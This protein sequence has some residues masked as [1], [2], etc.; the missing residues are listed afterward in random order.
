M[1]ARHLFQQYATDAYAKVEGERLR[2]VRSHQKE[3]R[4]DKYKGL[5]DAV[6]ENDTINAGQ[7]VILPPTYTGGPRWLAEEFQDSMALVRK[8]GKPDYFVTF[9]AK[10]SWP[11]ITSSLFP[12][13][14]PQDRQDICDRV[15]QIKHKSLLEDL[16]KWEVLGKVKAFTSTIEFQKRGL[17]H[18]HILLIMA[19][20]DKPR[21]PEE[22][23]RVVS[24]EIPDVTINPELHEIVTTQMVHGPC[25][26]VNP[27]SPCMESSAG[28][29]I[30]GKDFPKQFKESTSINPNGYPLYRRRAP[31]DGG[32]TH[33]TTVKGQQFTIDNRWIV[34]YNPFLSLKYK[35]HLNVEIVTSVECVKYIY[36]YICKGSDRVVI[37]LANGD[38]KDITNDEIECFV[39]ARYISSSQAL[40]R[41]Y[42]FNLSQ[43]H[44]PVSKLPL[45]LEDEQ[46]VYF[47]PGNASEV[48]SRP[49]PVTKLTGYFELN[50]QTSESHHILYPDIYKHYVWKDNKWVK[51]SRDWSK[52]K[53][54][55]AM[56]DIVGRIPVI[57]LNAQQIEL[58]H[59][60][61]LLYHI[62]GAKSFADLRTIN[63]VEEPTFRAA[64]L[65]M[66]LLDDD[67]ENDRAIEEAS[68]IRF[69]PQ[70]RETFAMLLIWNSPID[71]KAFWEKHKNILSEDLLRR[72]GLTEP[73][74]QILNEVLLNIEEYVQRNGFEIE[75]FQLPKP[76]HNL[77]SN[78]IPREIREESEYD[79]EMMTEIVQ[80]NVPLLNED[81]QKVYDTIIES[82]NTGK[83]EII[84]LDAA[85]GSGKTFLTTTIL[86]TLRSQGKVALAT[87]T[88]G[89]AATL[90]LNGR[91]LHSRCKVPVEGLNEH[92]FCNISKRGATAELIRRA[93]FLVVDEVTM[94]RREVYEA[95][96]RTFQDI[97]GNNLPFG[98]ITVLLS[99]DWRQIL[100]VVRHGGRADIVHACLKRSHLWKKVKVIKLTKNMRLNKD[101]A[102]FESFAQQ[103]LQIGEGKVPVEED[104]GEFKIKVDDDFL[105]NEETL[106]ALC[107]FVWNGLEDHYNEPEWLCSRAVLCPTNEA[108]DEV[109]TYM[110]E[111]FPGEE[112]CYF[113]SDQLIEGNKQ[114][115]PEEFLNTLSSSG[116]PPHKLLL[117][118]KCPV[119]LMRNLD[120]SKGHCNGTRYVISGMYDHVIDATIATGV[121][122][123]RRIMIP[124]IPTCPSES[125]FPFRMHRRQYPLRTCFGMTANKS[126][127]QGLKRIGIY[128]KKRFFS[129]GQLYVAMSR[130][131]S[132]SNIKIL[133]KDGRFPGKEG[134]YMDNVVYPEIL[135]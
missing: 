18:S 88:S 16:L 76:D 118:E 5:L 2:W 45:H 54:G 91:T 119:M 48:A 101:D 36:K 29:K 135:T 1:K 47:Q 27:L 23:D 7:K 11:E 24:A 55:S 134:V 96:D 62:P 41:L 90:L 68:S 28:G 70:L 12:G 113:S 92:S 130:V 72:D 39:N 93:V 67:S 61:M 44:P 4:A 30:C 40:W 108:A 34:P 58:Y 20:S 56:S 33:N 103:L 129:H 83:G 31:E 87:A 89:I 84:A 3:I 133:A 95:V 126:Q 73:N 74:D 69:G 110:T 99:G 77:M 131:S 102:N 117:K 52:E 86:A 75:K 46:M 121:H 42:E 8:Y 81:Q 111:H 97:R 66:G 35:A 15:F 19:D 63:G 38:E 25:G 122:V 120:P 9:T 80:Q 105:L 112:R 116:M 59:L 124:R 82:V 128:L 57:N 6:D 13:Q 53:D 26:T 100:P 50:K 14:S 115:F 106:E 22:I 104:L 43:I 94:A 127:G 65:K 21:T 64:C 125:I 10:P 132:K 79:I 32:R 60:R 71:P 17:P 78:S 85:G 98:G 123:G 49:P 114:Q 107:E 37:K 51:R 109:N